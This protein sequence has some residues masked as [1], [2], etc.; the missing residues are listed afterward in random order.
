MVVFDMP[1]DISTILPSGEG[2]PSRSSGTICAAC[3]RPAF[4][5]FGGH[6]ILATR[7]EAALF[8][9]VSALA[10]IVVGDETHEVA[11]RVQLGI[12]RHEQLPLL[13]GD[14]AA[15]VF[16]IDDLVVLP[17]GGVVDLR[18]ESGQGQG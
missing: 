3:S 7:I 9:L 2:L 16:A 1:M 14:V 5:W 13:L 12:H 17:A 8:A 15:A 18:R 6:G 11:R 4:K 10:E